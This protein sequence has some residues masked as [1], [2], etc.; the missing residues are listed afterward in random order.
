MLTEQAV[1]DRYSK[2]AARKEDA[3]CCAVTYDPRY[4]EVIPPEVLDIDYGCGD[5]SR[6]L[7]TGETVLDL[8]SGAGKICFIASQVVGSSGR[9]IGIDMNNEMLALARKANSEVS[10]RLGYN[11]VVFHKGKIQDLRI[12]RE[13]LDNWLR[14]HPVKTESDL[15]ALETHIKKISNASPM[16]HDESIDVT[17]SNCVLNLVNH[18]DKPILFKEIYRVLKRG[19]RAA[20]SDIVSDE[21]VPL[22]LQED[23]TLWSGCISGALQ[24]SEFIKAFE[25]A[26]FYGIMI[27]KRDE[28]PWRTVHGIEFRSIT[29]LAYKGKEGPCWD[30]KEAVVY[31]GPFRE[32]SDD[33][34]H[35]FRRGIRVAVCRKTFT[36][37]GREPYAHHFE[38]IKPPDE[39]PHEDA[40]PF[41]CTKEMI[42]RPP[43]ETK[44]NTDNTTAGNNSSCCEPGIRC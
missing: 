28:K 25:D 41:P 21:P 3:L 31:K 36:I 23:P 9:V 39:I 37:L 22:E 6:Y 30:Y 38:F 40:L 34:G 10:A 12:D 35:R 26:G 29:V 13:A 32:V 27:V 16:I 4:L 18:N 15:T 2:A 8:G 42:V 20:I 1:L 17:V 24:E 33:D 11:N 43:H 5:P 19:G 14:R 44:G 7:H